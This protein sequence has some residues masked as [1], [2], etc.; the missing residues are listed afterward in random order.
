LIFKIRNNLI[1]ISEEID[2]GVCY[3]CK[4]EIEKGLIIEYSEYIN[5]QKHIVNLPVHKECYR[6]SKN[7]NL[8][9][10][11]PKSFYQSPIKYKNSHIFF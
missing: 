8:R 7:P 10:I 11:K 4:G 2:E 1:E 5:N 3:L 9:L 6:L